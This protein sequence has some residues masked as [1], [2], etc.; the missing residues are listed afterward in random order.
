MK[1]LL[2]TLA[3]VL[4]LYCTPKE[5]PAE[6]AL[7]T[8]KGGYSMVSQSWTDGTEVTENRASQ[9]KIYTDTHIIYAGIN[10]D[11]VDYFGIG[12]Y[13]INDGLVT[14]TI[15]YTS[16][17]TSSNDERNTVTLEIEKTE[18]GYTQVIRNMETNDGTFTLTESYA[19]T[20]NGKSSIFDGAWKCTNMTIVANNDSTSGVPVQYKVYYDG[21]VIWAHTNSDSTGTQSTGIGYGTFETVSDTEIKETIQVSTYAIAGQT[22]TLVIEM[23]DANHFRQ[24]ITGDDVIQIEE[25]ERIEK[26]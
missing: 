21:N 1:N 14:E 5:K 23:P 26:R 6:E 22:F 17:D 25:Y 3:T 20:G 11:S 13:T 2:L 15:F 10:E 7:S 19:Y 12:E 24:T 18:N 8:I 16:G 4:L 9:H